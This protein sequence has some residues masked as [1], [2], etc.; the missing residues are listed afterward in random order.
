M[1]KIP[2]ILVDDEPLALDLLERYVLKTPFLDCRFRCNSAVEAM[3]YLQ[4]NQTDLIF[5]DIQMPELSGIEFSR[6]IDP[7]TKVIFTTAFNEYAIEGFRVN[8]LDYLL[9]PF[10]FEEFFRAA[11][12]AREWFRV[13]NPAVNRESIKNDYIFVKSEYK[14]I[15]IH[16][17]EVLYFEGL[18][19]Y[20]KIWVKDCPRPKMTLMSL[21]TLEME[22]PRDKFMRIHR[23]FIVALDK[24]RFVERG[25][26]IIS[27]DI[28]IT[29]AEQYKEKFQ[30]FIS[31]KSIG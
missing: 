7:N 13:I 18:K 29:I 2:C 10:N 24:I 25:Q 30:E 9:K 21:K 22:L 15:K 27:D 12:K 28:R 20:I 16:L 8:A 17:N 14:N 19:D 31:C 1:K 23:S 3:D 11:N 6:I 4:K 5:L 26:V